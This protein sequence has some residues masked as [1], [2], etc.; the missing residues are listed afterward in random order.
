MQAPKSYDMLS[1]QA[2]VNFDELRDKYKN[3]A[4]S[5]REKYKSA[6]SS[7]LSESEKASAIDAMQ[8]LDDYK[9]CNRCHGIGTVKELYNHFWQEKDCPDCE[10]EA[11]ML[12]QIKNIKDSLSTQED[13]T[14]PPEVEE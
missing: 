12:K 10:G 5:E 7:K 14:A 13:Q 4:I 9:I 3:V 2:G 11:I 8:R 1:S 6:Q